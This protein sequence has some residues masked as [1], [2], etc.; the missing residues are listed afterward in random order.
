MNS[1]AVLV[2]IVAI[3][4]GLYITTRDDTKVKSS[5]DGKFEVIH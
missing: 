4:Y 5:N 3:L 2:A 1:F